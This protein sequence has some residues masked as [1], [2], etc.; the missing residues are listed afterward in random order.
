MAGGIDIAPS[1]GAV[2]QAR[3]IAE[4][5]AWRLELDDL[6]DAGRARA[7]VDAAVDAVRVRGGGLL[8]VWR[9]N[10]TPATDAA[11]LAAGL[12]AHRDL[13]QMRRSL[14][15][16]PSVAAPLPVRSF[17]PGE[18]EV[19]WLEVNN[20]AFAWH[21]EQSNWDLATLVERESQ[22]WFD[23]DG[24]LLYEE[25]GRLAG[26]CW[27]K[28]HPGGV[29][30]IYVIGVDPEFGGRGLG[31]RLTVAG[32]DHLSGRGQTVAMLYVEGTND[33]ALAL[34]DHLGFVVQERQRAYA[35]AVDPVTPP[36]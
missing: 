25:G 32:L 28:V 13:L 2:G 16:P 21:P 27:T 4:P 15:L 9:T 35:R 14:P 1:D 6:E 24:F 29:G 31:R 12:V 3:L 8:Q 19:A 18:D 7:L 10:P 17:V 23:P 34:Y 36:R 5:R 20:R 22:P 30:E 26:F 11:A 33:V